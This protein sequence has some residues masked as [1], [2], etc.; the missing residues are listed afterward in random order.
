MVEPKTILAWGMTIL[1]AS[2]ATSK[3]RMN[4]FNTEMARSFPLG[5][6]VLVFIVNTGDGCERV[7]RCGGSEGSE[8]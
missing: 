2:F 8:S 6:C 3:V 5:C 1:E 4:P 7:V